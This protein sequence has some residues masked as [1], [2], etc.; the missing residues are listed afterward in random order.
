MDDYFELNYHSLG[1]S[2]E[3]LLMASS[4]FSDSVKEDYNSYIK[5]KCEFTS[6]MDMK[7]W[8]TDGRG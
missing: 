3:V 8:L 7:R 6:W 4:Y 1:T 2:Q 5:S